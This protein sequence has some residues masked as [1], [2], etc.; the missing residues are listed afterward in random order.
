PARAR[1][2]RARAARDGSALIDVAAVISSYRSEADLPACVQSLRAGTTTPSPIVVA[3]A[4][5]DGA[6]AE[7]ARALGVELLAL[8]NRGL[9]YLY[10]RG[11][12]RVDAT[13]VLLAN[14][15]TAFE[16]ACVE[17]LRAALERDAAAFA[18]DPRQLDWS[19]ARTIRART[20]LRRGP[21]LRTTVPGLT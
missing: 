20:V 4:S 5:P 6:S 11:V 12:G 14:A 10:N 1:A 8:E 2:R 18:A 21:L 16:A 15:D 17:R 9:G 19:G 13:Y 7:V 3:D